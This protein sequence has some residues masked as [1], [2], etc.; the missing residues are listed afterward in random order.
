MIEIFHVSDLYFGM[1]KTWTK[2]DTL[3]SRTRRGFKGRS[4]ELGQGDSEDL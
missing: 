2:I 4:E 1:N 3:R